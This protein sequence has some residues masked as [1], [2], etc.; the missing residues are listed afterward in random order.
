MKTFFIL[1]SALFASSFAFVH[2]SRQIFFATLMFVECKMCSLYNVQLTMSK[3]HHNHTQCC[4]RSCMQAFL[5]QH[6]HHHIKI[7]DHHWES[8]QE[9]LDLLYLPRHY[10]HHQHHRQHHHH[11]QQ[12]QNLHYRH[13]PHHHYDHDHQ[14]EQ[15]HHDHI[16]NL[17]RNDLSCSICLDII[18]D[19]D[20][21]ITSD[22]TED[23]IVAFAKVMWW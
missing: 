4:A 18:T 2:K 17:Y 13:R 15:H 23:Q 9:R 8:S 19:L 10:Y 3:V 11:H 1:F 6:N 5:N 7:I 14:H 22:T 20:N 16:Q 12:H 21:F